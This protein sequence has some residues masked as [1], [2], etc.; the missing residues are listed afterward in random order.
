M[1]DSW[2]VNS[3]SKS[4]PASTQVSSEIVDGR[5]G[6]LAVV[7]GS[8]ISSIA[9][10]GAVTA[11]S[12][13]KDLVVGSGITFEDRGEHELRGVPG[14]WTVHAVVKLEPRA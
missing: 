14:A 1:L 11:W 10:A 9:P 12:T 2:N 5:P 6:G 8:R 3:D 4:R 7:V 13:V